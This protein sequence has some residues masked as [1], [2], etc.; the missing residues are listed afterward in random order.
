VDPFPQDIINRQAVMKCAPTLFDLLSVSGAEERE[1]TVVDNFS[2][3]N[4]WLTNEN[5]HI[6]YT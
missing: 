4:K 5:S 1:Q 2:L 3:W 6:H